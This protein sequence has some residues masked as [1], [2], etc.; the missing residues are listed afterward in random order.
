M[1]IRSARI[2]RQV[3]AC[4]LITQLRQGDRAVYSNFV[5]LKECFLIT[6]P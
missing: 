3:Q 5:N 6:K 1:V 4:Q 2:G